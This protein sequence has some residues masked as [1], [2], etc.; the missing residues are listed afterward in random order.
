MDKELIES[1][2]KYVQT[3]KSMVSLQQVTHLLSIGALDRKK[4]LYFVIKSEYFDMQKNSDASGR[5]AM[6][7]LSVKW[8]VSSDTIKNIIYLMPEIKG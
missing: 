4:A 3:D 7:Y 5:D 8:D 6:I 2:C 1:F